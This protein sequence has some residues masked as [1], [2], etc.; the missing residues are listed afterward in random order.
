MGKVIKLPP[1]IRITS[2]PEATALTPANILQG[3]IGVEFPV[4]G[5]IPVFERYGKVELYGYVV[6]KQKA[7]RILRRKSPD[8]AD[9]IEKHPEIFT[10]PHLVFSENA[11]ERIGF[12]QGGGMGK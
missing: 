1:R 2:S 10:K 6:N 3:F 5:I 9:Y 4:E 8:T 12:H 11:C 7:L